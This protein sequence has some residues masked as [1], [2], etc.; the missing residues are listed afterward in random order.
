MGKIKLLQMEDPEAVADRIGQEIVGW[1]LNKPQLTEE[2]KGKYGHLFQQKPFNG[3]VVGL[4]GG[5][6]STCVGMC[7]RWGIRKYNLDNENKIKLYGLVMPAKANQE[8]DTEDG[9]RIAK[10]LDIPYHVMP[11][12]PILDSMRQ[13]NP[14]LAKEFN[15]GN[16]SS[17]IRMIQLYAE[18]NDKGLIVLGTGNKDEDYGLGYFTKYGDGGVDFSPIGR[19]PK[20]LVRQLVGY[21]G[22]RLGLEPKLV[23]YYAGRTATAGLW[24]GQ[25]DEG[26]L[27]FSYDEAE[28]VIAGT[29]LNMDI[30]EIK[31][32]T[33]IEQAKIEKIIKMHFNNQHKMGMPPIAELKG[34]L[35]YR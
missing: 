10:L 19:L 7:A 9:E 13:V 23:D 33:G 31:E 26:E 4:S 6:D 2:V 11:I 21:I 8:K 1:I 34:L 20:R 14:A 16:A 28:I 12:E 3:A 35:E 25:T 5:V 24:P 30:E 32:E 22:K 18:A 15:A 27:G 17:R 29:D